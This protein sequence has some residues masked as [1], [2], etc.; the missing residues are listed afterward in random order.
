MRK[1]ESESEIEKEQQMKNIMKI[2][3]QS[4]TSKSNRVSNYNNKQG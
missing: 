2:D 3:T 4:E 1:R